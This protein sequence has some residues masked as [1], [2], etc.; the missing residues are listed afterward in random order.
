MPNPARIVARFEVRLASDRYFYA[1]GTT[2]LEKLMGKGREFGV[3]S[4]YRSGLS[5]S[6]NQKRHGQLM[7]DLQRMGYKGM[8]PLKSSWEDMATKVTHKEK[9]IFIPH[10]SFDDLHKLGKKYEQDA[11]LYKDKS[12]SIGVYFKDNSA[13]MAFNNE[14]E[15]AVEKSTDRNEGYSKG[16]GIGFGL[17]LIEDKKFTYDGKPITKDKLKKELGADTKP[18]GDKSE[19]EDDKPKKDEGKGKS[20]EN[21]LESQGDRK[22]PNPNPKSRDQHPQVAIKSLEWDDQKKYYDQWAQHQ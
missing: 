4:A 15:A 19:K 10:I 2:D 14:A 7:A 11:V 9:S 3:I 8:E 21:F 16:R 22:V 6:E 20:K 13:I 1:F 17:N 12:G 18:K 5:K